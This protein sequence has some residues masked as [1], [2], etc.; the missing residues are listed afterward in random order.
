[1]LKWFMLVYRVLVLVSV[2]NIELNMMNVSIVCWNLNL[3]VYMGFS[4]INICGD[5]VIE[6]SFISF[7]SRN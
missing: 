1:M 7:S 5:F 4:V 6:I 3:M 2:R